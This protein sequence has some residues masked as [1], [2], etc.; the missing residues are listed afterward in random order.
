M[1]ANTIYFI[2][3]GTNIKITLEA[4]SQ[5]ILDNWKNKFLKPSKDYVTGEFK[6][7]KK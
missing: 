5:E 3:D 7:G 2:F 1:V 6:K 4:N